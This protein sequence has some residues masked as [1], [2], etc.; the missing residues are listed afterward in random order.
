[1]PIS[2]PCPAFPLT[3]SCLALLWALPWLLGCACVLLVFPTFPFPSCLNLSY[4]AVQTSSSS[5]LL[6]A[7]VAPS[8]VPTN[9]NTNISFVVHNKLV[10]GHHSS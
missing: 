1:M 7:L 4:P 10:G 9:T 6:L 2:A 8:F 3:L 5:S